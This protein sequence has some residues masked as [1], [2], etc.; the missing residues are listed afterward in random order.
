M[1]S[2]TIHS[3]N[4]IPYPVVIAIGVVNSIHE[5]TISVSHVKSTNDS[6]IQLVVYEGD[7]PIIGQLDI[8]NYLSNTY[9]NIL[10]NF[11]ESE[12]WINFAIDKLTNKNFSQLSTSLEELNHNLNF[13]SLIIGNDFS[14]ADIVVWGSLRSNG[15]M[16]SILKN[17]VYLNISRWYAYLETQ[18]NPLVEQFNKLKQQQQPSKGQPHKASM[19]F[20]LDNTEVGKVVTRF[21]PEP[22]GYLH[23]GHVKTAIL[24]QYLAQSYKGKLLIR[25]DDTNPDKESMEFTNAIVDDLQLL[26]IKG[27]ATSYTSDHFDELYEYAIKL[28]KKGLAYCD[29]TPVEKM[30]EERME[31]EESIHRNRSIESTL[32]IFTQEMKN[33]TSIGLLNCL[34]A[35]IDYK[36]PNKALRDPVIYR[37]NLT[38]HHKIGT[39]WK[40]YPNYDFCAPVVD[41]IEGVTHALRAN[42]YRDRNPQYTWFLES[43]DLR[44]VTIF[45]FGKIN[46]VRTV[47]SKR[48]LKWIVENGY[49]NG[50][51]DPRMPTVKGVMRRGMSIEG[52][53]NFIL[54]QGASKNIINLDWSLIWALNKQVIDPIAPRFTA[55]QNND[56]VTVELISPT[57]IEPTLED[58]PKHKKNPALVSKSVVFSDKILIEQI[59]AASFE[60]G[61]EITLMDWGNIVIKH[62]EIKDGKVTSIR[63]LLHLEGDFKKTS[64]KITWLSDTNDKVKVDLFEFD[65]LITKDKILDTENFQDFL[66]PITEFKKSAWA[67]L[68]VKQLRKGDIIQFERKGYYRVDQPFGSDQPVLLFLIPDGKKSKTLSK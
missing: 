60:V 8:L 36:N 65:Y 58:R 44:I 30:R 53:R 43:L 15:M 25:F 55:I 34:R 21:L 51:D 46:F 2:L 13:R 49:V 63:A 48:K 4:S 39:T 28:I 6:L 47:L 64:K 52:L 22:S 17:Q 1:T 61:E 32:Q 29:D 38:P 50:W 18:L 41:S 37:C 42:E 31:G 5:N 45:D 10:R 24:N 9:P 14:L 35:K 59:D 16:V 20:G 23:I 54:S 26:G 11:T 67:D 56:V 3:S 57:A 66:T 27:D 12:N 68:N 40:M 33:G 7:P 62:I 19:A